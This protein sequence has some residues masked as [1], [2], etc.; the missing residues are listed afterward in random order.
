MTW[1]LQEQSVLQRK[2]ALQ[3]SVRNIRITINN[4]CIRTV[5]TANEEHF[6][7]EITHNSNTIVLVILAF[8]TLMGF[9]SYLHISLVVETYFSITVFILNLLYCILLLALGGCSWPSLMHE[10]THDFLKK[11]WVT[12]PK[13]YTF[14]TDPPRSVHKEILFS[15]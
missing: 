10:V 1:S 6:V 14:S 12:S 9:D 13:V 5:S 7:N 3:I 15:R 4:I 8:T 2:G 11:V